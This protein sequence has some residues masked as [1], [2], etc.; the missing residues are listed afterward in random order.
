MHQFIIFI[1]LIFIGGCKE[2]VFKNSPLD[3]TTEF[4]QAIK[5]PN[6]PLLLSYSSCAQLTLYL[7]SK[8]IKEMEVIMAQWPEDAPEWFMEPGGGLVDMAPGAPMVDAPGLATEGLDFS[9]TNNQEKGVDEAD[10]IKTDGKYFYIINQNNF[11]ILSI[12]NDGQLNQ[13]SSIALENAPESLLIMGNKAIFFSNNWANDSVL[14]NIIEMDEERQQLSNPKS[15]YFEGMLKAAR[16][17]GKKIYIATYKQDLVPGLIYYPELPDN[18]E[19][20]A[21]E[22]QQR[23]WK[24]AKA[25]AKLA[26]EAILESYDYLKMLPSEIKQEDLGY[27]RVQPAESDCT[28]AQGII[29]R[30]SEGYVALISLDLETTESSTSIF[31][32]RSNYPIVYASPEQILIAS[33]TFYFTHEGEEN[34]TIHRLKIGSDEKLLYKDFLKVPGQLK[35]SFALS[36]YQGYIRLAT[37]TRDYSRDTWD[38]K[39]HLYILGDE[40]GKFSIISALENLAPGESIWAVRFSKDKGFLVTFEQVDPLFTLDLSDPKN[41]FVAGTLKVPGVSTYL[42]DIGDNQLLAI[43][44]GGNEEGLNWQASISLFDVSDFRNPRLA[45]SLS[46]NIAEG[47]DDSWSNIMSE[48]LTNHLAINYFGPA[49]MT[50]IPVH[51]ERYIWNEELLSGHLE[52]ISKLMVI[53]TKKDQELTMLGQIDHSQY[54]SNLDGLD[55]Y[56]TPQ[57]RR[58]YFINNFLYGISSKVITATKLDDMSTVDAYQLK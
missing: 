27:S 1:A 15:Y 14:I 58:S 32:A 17:I 25:K 38:E 2:G 37:T 12:E 18:Y 26:N 23:L 48:A 33:Q 8:A 45:Q 3:F 4:S 20:L 24:E 34:T 35:D 51:T 10:I 57:I 16:K 28:E 13:K 7:K 50:A 43:G 42:Q 39:N 41:P 53:N 19:E 30:K 47:L 52:T 36:E 55:S 46:F 6:E 5:S 54:Y 11:E 22:E 29:D 44:Y 21:T 31:R 49:G 56:E 9:G 40:D